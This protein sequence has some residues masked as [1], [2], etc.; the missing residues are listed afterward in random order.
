VSPRLF[1]VSSRRCPGD[2]FLHLADSL[3]TRATRVTRVYVKLLTVNDEGANVERG[4][5]TATARG[6]L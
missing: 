1:E 6:A 5:R 4:R 2:C 3:V